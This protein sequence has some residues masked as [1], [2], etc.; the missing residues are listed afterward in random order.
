SLR[1][2]GT[3]TPPRNVHEPLGTRNRKP[4]PAFCANDGGAIV[5][6]AMVASSN[7]VMSPP[8][9]AFLTLRVAGPLRQPFQRIMTCG[10]PLACL[11]SPEHSLRSPAPE[12][13]RCAPR[14]IL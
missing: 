9:T 5:R 12:T 10:A 3:A 8:C 13:R 2:V 1:A 14:P 4:S 7:L 11:P 6:P